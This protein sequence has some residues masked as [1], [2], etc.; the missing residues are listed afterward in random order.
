GFAADRSRH[1]DGRGLA[2]KRLFEGDLEIIA[3]VRAALAPRRMPAAPAPHHVA[4]QIVE[5]VRH[6]RRKAVVHPALVEGGMAVTVVGRAL[7][8][9]GEMLV[10]FVQLLEARLGLLV[11]RMPVGVT[12]HRRLAEGGLEF[13][14][15]RCFGNAEGLVEIALGHRSARP[16]PMHVSALLLLRRFAAGR[17]A[18]FSHRRKHPRAPCPRQSDLRPPSRRP[19]QKGTGLAA[20]QA[21]GPFVHDCFLSSSTSRNSASMT[22][23]LGCPPAP[24][25][26]SPPSPGAP[27]AAACALYMASPSFICACIRSLVRALIASTSSPCNAVRNEATADSMALRSDW[28][29]LSP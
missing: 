20:L 23:S 16:Q 2:V 24:A 29:T 3:Q 22:S 1:A 6:R 19:L 7:L 18:R 28:A 9:V 17:R 25:P 21:A 26:P 5:N 8:G 4:E 15:G 10:G 11:A 14:V 12:L 13:G 27:P